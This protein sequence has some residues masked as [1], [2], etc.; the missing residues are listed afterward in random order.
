LP[1][2]ENPEYPKIG[3]PYSKDVA[4]VIVVPIVEISAFR[5]D[6]MQIYRAIKILD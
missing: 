5:L 6:K 3:P 1:P 2:V 4:S